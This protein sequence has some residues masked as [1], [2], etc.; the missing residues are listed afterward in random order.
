M[1][2]SEEDR[3]A[4]QPLVHLIH[5]YPESHFR[6]TMKDGA[7]LL[8]SYDTMY[9]TENEMDD[10]DPAYEEFHACLFKIEQVLFCKPECQRKYTGKSYLEVTYHNFP[11][12]II[13]IP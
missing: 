8:C 11:S 5:S 12:E 6:I 2:F 4:M 13:P 7:Q 10:E 1:Y 9:E 3:K